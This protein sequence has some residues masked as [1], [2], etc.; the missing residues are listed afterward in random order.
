[1]RIA[2]CISG[3]FRKFSELY[4]NWFDLFYSPLSKYNQVD[5]FIHTW[6]ELNSSD[7]FSVQQLDNIVDS[8]KL[9]E[10]HFRS[11]LNPVKMVVE[12][13][14]QIK[15]N[16]TID[17]YYKPN[18]KI[19]PL[20][21]NHKSKIQYC[22]PM[23]Y[24]WF[25]CNEL[26]KKKEKEENFKYDLVVKCR[27]DIFFFREI[28]PEEFD[29]NYVYMR[30][31]SQDFLIF[32]SSEN[33]DRVTSIYANLHNLINKYEC[34]YTPEQLCEYHFQENGLDHSKMKCFGEASCWVYPRRLFRRACYDILT[35]YNR[36]NDFY[37][38]MKKYGAKL[39][40]D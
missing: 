31:P 5:I 11:L 29:P 10:I 13:F 34:E 6:S 19:H 22:F 36:R 18:Q 26:K 2:I 28:R 21:Y 38:L 25:S 32:G 9:D 23:F 15:D 17:K 30:T 14:A 8:N 39:N 37:Y 40:H 16:F 1:M 35:K 12:D 33:I 20:V 27:P 24:K 7:C 4:R 3:H